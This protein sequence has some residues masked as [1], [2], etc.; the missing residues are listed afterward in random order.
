MVV[1]NNARSKTPIYNVNMATKPKRPRDPNQ[2]ARLIVGISTGEIKDL[3]PNAGKNPSA[4]ERGQKGGNVG[5]KAR[6]GALSPER[7]QEIAKKAAEDRWK[8]R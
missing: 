3:D 8:K 5:G 4:I 2:L 6:A 7:R 1:T